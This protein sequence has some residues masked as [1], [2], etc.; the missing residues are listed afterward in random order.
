M[1]WATSSS[2]ILD[3]TIVYPDGTPTFWHFLQG[4]VRRVVV[5]ARLLPIPAHLVNADYS[6]DAEVRLQ[7][8][9]WVQ[10]L[11]RDKDALIGDILRRQAPG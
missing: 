10:Q 11:W 1:P 2:A 6:G 8:Q 3:I 9:A 7:Y 4:R 5:R